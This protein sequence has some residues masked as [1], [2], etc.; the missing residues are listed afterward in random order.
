DE[1]NNKSPNP[2]TI[3]FLPDLTTSVAGPVAATAGTP[4]NYT[5]T[6][7]NLSNTAGASNVTLQ[8]TL[9]SGV[10]YNTAS[11][12]HGFS[13][14]QS[15]GI[16]TFTGGSL[17]ISD[18]A[19]LTISLTAASVGTINLP[20]GAA[21]IDPNNTITESNETNNSSTAAVATPVRSTVLPQ[22]VGDTY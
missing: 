4:Y 2:V 3:S 9:P 10:T 21:I 13:A 18:S 16:V 12:D 15:N 6:A 20:V 17:G 11:G 1:G 22:A 5:V 8:F 14:S 19:T 7:A